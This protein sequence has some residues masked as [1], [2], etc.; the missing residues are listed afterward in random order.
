LIIYL[1]LES[2]K[3]VLGHPQ[4]QL[5]IVLLRLYASSMKHSIRK[6]FALFCGTIHKFVF[7]LLI[8]WVVVLL[9]HGLFFSGR[10]GNILILVPHSKEVLCTPLEIVIYSPLEIN[11]CLRHCLIFVCFVLFYLFCISYHPWR[12]Y[13]GVGLFVSFLVLISL[14]AVAFIYYYFVLIRIRLLV[15]FDEMAVQP[16]L[17]YGFIYLLRWLSSLSCCTDSF[18]C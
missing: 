5:N 9:L 11:Y 4:I 16:V 7:V 3:Y 14:A 18:T 8:P 12:S 17:L 1:H 6:A 2:F 15:R 13:G 10:C